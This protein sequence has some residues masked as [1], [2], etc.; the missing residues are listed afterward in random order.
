MEVE[1]RLTGLHGR[2][3]E[4]ARHEEAAER[5]R[6]EA[7][8]QQADA[9]ARQQQS[10]AQAAEMAA[11]ARPRPPADDGM[12]AALR[13]LQ[14][15]MRALKHRAADHRHHEYAPPPPPQVVYLAPP[16]MPAAA[17]SPAMP[18]LPPAMPARSGAPIDA[19]VGQLTAARREVERMA[20]R[21]SALHTDILNSIKQMRTPGS[22]RRSASHGGGAG[23]GG[24]GTQDFDAWRSD[25]NQRLGTAVKRLEG[26]M[27]DGS[28]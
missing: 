18:P 26:A 15:E 28:S 13:E 16:P 21:Q 9:A 20:A 25:M 19:E 22:G 17:A 14:A 2:L 6:V 27:T 7:L 23:G 3:E 4:L 5:R 11:A 24:G 10:S 8:R 1:G 12:E